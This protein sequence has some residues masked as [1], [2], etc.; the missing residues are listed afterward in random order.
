MAAKILPQVEVKVL[1]ALHK[2]V[3]PDQF[4]EKNGSLNIT[5][6]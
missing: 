1:S 3:I 2:M 6:E 5:S 4:K